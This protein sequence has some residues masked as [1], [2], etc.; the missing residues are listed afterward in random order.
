MAKIKSGS[1][2]QDK[3]TAKNAKH[4]PD[5]KIDYSDVPESTDEELSRAVRVGRP[6]SSNRKQLI[7]IRLAPSL[8]SR[9]K[10]IAKAQDV[11]YQTLIHQL[12]EEAVDEVA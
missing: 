3:R 7:A 9:L 6:T 10:K 2:A 12:L 8:I 1:S 5:S 11:P 4:T